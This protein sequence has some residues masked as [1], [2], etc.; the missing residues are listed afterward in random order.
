[1]YLTTS[2]MRGLRPNSVVF[3]CEMYHLYS[4]T[5]FS[6]EVLPSNTE[7]NQTTTNNDTA[8]DDDDDH[9]ATIIDQTDHNRPSSLPTS[10]DD[11]HNATAIDQTDHNQPS[12]LPTSH[13]DDH[14]AT[15][16]DQTDHN[17]PSSLPTSHKQS[18]HSLLDSGGIM[19]TCKTFVVLHRVTMI[20][21]PSWN[22]ISHGIL[23][24]FSKTGQ[25][26]LIIGNFESGE[27]LHE[28]KLNSTSSKYTAQRTYFH[29]F[30][31]DGNVYGLGFVEVDVAT[32]VFQ[33]VSRLLAESQTVTGGNG[34]VEGIPQA[35]RAK[36]EDDKYSEWVIID[37]EDIPAINE[38]TNEVDGGTDEIDFG[39]FSRKKTDDEKDDFKIDNVSETSYFRHIPNRPTISTP[40]DFR[41]LTHMASG[42]GAE[43]T[44]TGG[45]ESSSNVEMSSPEIYEK[46]TK[47]SSSFMEFSQNEIETESQS[48]PVQTQPAFPVPPSSYIGTSGSGVAGGDITSSSSF[49]S[50]FSGSSFSIPDPPSHETSHDTLLSQINTF[51]RKALHHVTSDEANRALLQEGTLTAIL[52][53]SFDKFRPKLQAMYS[54]S[55]VASINTE[56]DEEWSDDEIDGPL[57]E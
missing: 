5:V 1:M 34:V 12:S 44:V 4:Y 3:S 10:H 32:K 39:L 48:T 40:T 11:D 51:D 55:T 57:F 14:N 29:T 46:G 20:T 27:I 36:I 23:T 47:R 26:S 31:A 41:H 37:R 22:V 17:Q 45:N 30:V 15:A 21:V 56:G 19:L 16:I 52:Q 49:A 54:V 7:S 18:L 9:N 6:M 24:I 42:K 13:D 50:T 2:E 28:F 38:V 53:Q 33:V 35:K 43:S 8:A 25:V